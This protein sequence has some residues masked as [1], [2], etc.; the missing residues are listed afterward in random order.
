[1]QAIIIDVDLV[2]VDPVAATKLGIARQS[3][4]VENST[5][6]LF[7]DKNNED[8]KG[9]VAEMAFE[10]YSGLPMS[11]ELYGGAGDGG[12]DFVFNL[13]GKPTTI[14]V[15]GSMKPYHLLVKCVGIQR[16]ADILVLAG[17]KDENVQFLGWEHKAV[18]EVMPT[19]DFGVGPSHYKHRRDLIPM[20]K[21]WNLIWKQP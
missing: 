19:K 17:F 12:V 10:H 3:N 16:C 9:V 14:D 7:D 21:L 2:W 11:R 15:K 6:R 1:M 8:I 5:P 18:M 4:H 13:N 20:H